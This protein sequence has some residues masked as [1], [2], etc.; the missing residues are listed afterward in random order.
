MRQLDKYSQRDAAELVALARQGDMDAFEALILQHEKI[1]Y[2]IAFRMMGG[3]EDVKDMAQEVFLKVYRNLERFD[4]KSA[5]STWIYRIAVNTCIDEIR[6]RKGKQTYS[7]D[8]EL[9]DEDGNY[10]KQFADEGGRP[11]EEILQKEL[12]GEVLAALETLSPEH[13]AAVI[14]RDI[15]GYS[16]EEIAEMIQMPLGTV[17]S[18]ISRGRAQL[19]EEI[20]KI[21]ERKTDSSRQ[22]K[23][24]E[25]RKE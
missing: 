10:K 8:A 1:V 6:K 24:K 14:L 9:E 15:R 19:K 22:K 18:R 3:G 16:Y 23:G 11:E 21:R 12:R 17:K 2:N 5:F 25:G 13:K 4:G 20:L 7:L